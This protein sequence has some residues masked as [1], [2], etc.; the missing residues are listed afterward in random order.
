MTANT[1]APLASSP[2]D[3]VS[4]RALAQRALDT[5]DVTARLEDAPVSGADTIAVRSPINGRA[6]GVVRLEAEYVAQSDVDA[7]IARAVTV[8]E[9]WRSEPAP[10]RGEVVRH[11]GEQLRRHKEA[12]ADLVQIE[13]GKIRSEALGEVQE[14][15]DICDFAVG[16]SRQLH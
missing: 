6:L 8:F 2:F 5:M 15:I 4:L 9:S 11:L 14:M 16:L 7:A 1:N 13:V 10:R 12:L 3:S